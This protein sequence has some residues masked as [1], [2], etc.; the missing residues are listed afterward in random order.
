MTEFVALWSGVLAVKPSPV[1]SVTFTVYIYIHSSNQRNL[2]LWGE[3][4]KRLWRI[5][6]W[7]EADW[8]FHCFWIKWRQ[9]IVINYE[10]VVGHGLLK[11]GRRW[12]AACYFP[13][14]GLGG[15]STGLS[16]DKMSTFSRLWQWKSLPSSP[17]SFVGNFIS[18]SHAKIT[19]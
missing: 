12:N 9:T 19:C 11:D 18:T 13:S 4:G 14:V 5:W 1:S 8:T 6:Y 15:G 16:N 2:I 7:P 3:R 17:E 10:A